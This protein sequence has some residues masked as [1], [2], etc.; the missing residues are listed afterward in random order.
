MKYNG[1]NPTIL[2]GYGGF[3][4]SLT[5]GYRPVSGASWLDKRLPLSVDNCNRHPCYVI[6]NIRG[7]G[8][9]GPAWHKAALKE[10]RQNAY[11]DFIAIA[12]DLIARKITSSDHLGIEGGSNGGLLMGNMIVQR[13][14]LFGAVHVQVPLLDMKC[15]NKLLAGASWMAEYGDPD[16]PEVSQAFFFFFNDVQ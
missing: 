11:D 13:P 4:I 6:A 12:E 3:E 2:Y 10:N 15:Y 5:P 16:K 8:E 14:R 1:L 9:Y 7:G